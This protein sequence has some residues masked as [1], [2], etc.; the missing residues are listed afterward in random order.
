MLLESDVPLPDGM[1]TVRSAD[2]RR[3]AGTVSGGTFL[4]SGPVTDARGDLELC[5]SR[6]ADAGWFVVKSD[7]NSDTASAIYAKD[8]RVVDLTLRRRALEPRMSMGSLTVQTPVR[9]PTP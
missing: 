4:L 7:G 2:I 6:Y 5:S 1:S 9:A 8:T 3:A